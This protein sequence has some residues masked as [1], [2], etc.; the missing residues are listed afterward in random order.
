M[1]IYIYYLAPIYVYFKRF[2]SKGCL[3]VTPCPELSVCHHAGARTEQTV[4]V[5]MSQY[6]VTSQLCGGWLSSLGHLRAAIKFSLCYMCVCIARNHHFDPLNYSSI[7]HDNTRAFS[8]SKTSLHFRVFT[9]SHRYFLHSI[10]FLFVPLI[11]CKSL[12]FIFCSH[13]LLVWC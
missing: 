3:C 12:E 13:H 6:K 7:N 5:R 4:V 8:G 10:L 1:C 2:L 9:V 11:K